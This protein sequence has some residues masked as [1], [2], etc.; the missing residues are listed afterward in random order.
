[1][2]PSKSFLR[3]LT[4]NTRLK[5]KEN[6]YRYLKEREWLFNK[7]ENDMVYLVDASGVFGMGVRGEDIDWSKIGQRSHRSE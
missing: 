2:N 3:S 7:V 5:L 4:R 6:V 1:M